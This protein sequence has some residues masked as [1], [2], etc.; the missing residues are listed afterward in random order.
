[1]RP[2]FRCAPQV[3][4]LVGAAII[5]CHGVAAS[6]A[7]IIRKIDKTTAQ[8]LAAEAVY[9]RDEYLEFFEYDS[10]VSNNFTPPFFAYYGASK[11]PAE[12]SFGV[13][14][15]QPVDRRRVE[16]LGLPSLVHPGITQIASG[17]PP[18]VHARRTETIRPPAPS[19]AD[20][21]G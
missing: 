15:V 8:H 19:Q 13:F 17:D 6:E 4:A 3:F 16:S 5:L 14:A 21:H 9:G 2:I 7:E 12:G 20:V 1:M 18:T 10:G 11:P